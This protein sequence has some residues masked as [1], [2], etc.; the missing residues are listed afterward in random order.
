MA[1]ERVR[2]DLT[3]YKRNDFKMFVYFKK[4][5][6]TPVDL[7]GWTGYAQ[8]RADKDANAELL[9]TFDVTI[10]GLDGK[11]T[12]VLT[13]DETNPDGN[14][15]YYD[16]LMVDDEGFDETYVEGLVTFLDTV[17]VKA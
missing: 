5:D 17:T 16:L 10:E 6:D 2:Y 12:M 13:D 15:G 7:T 4:V 3:V 9:A 14:K 11:V 1:V 8:I